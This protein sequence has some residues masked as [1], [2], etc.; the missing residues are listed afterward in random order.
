MLKMFFSLCIILF[1]AISFAAEKRIVKINGFTQIETYKFRNGLQ[2]VLWPDKSYK[3]MSFHVWY[4]VGSLHERVG[5]TGLAHLFEHLM[6]RPSKFAP[7]G[8][9]ALSN[10]Y[11]ADVVAHTRFKTTDYEM[12]A[13]SEFLEPIAQYEADIM[14]NLTVSASVLKLEKEAVRSEYLN[15]DNSPVLTILP[16]LAAKLYPN[17]IAGEFVTGRRSDL[18]NMSLKNCIDFYKSFYSPDNAIITLTGNF[19]KNNALKIIKRYFGSLK[20][21]K[22]ISIPKDLDKKPRTSISSFKVKGNSRPMFSSFSFPFNTVN[23][24]SALTLALNILFDGKTSVVG[25]D[26]F[27]K[28]LVS[29]LSFEERGLG[30]NLIYSELTGKNSEKIHKYIKAGLKKLNVMR[31]DEFRRFVSKYSSSQIKR[32]QTVEQR[33]FELGWYLTHR[34]GLE[35]L[36]QDLEASKYITL[37]AVQRASQKYLR[38]NN[39]ISVV[40]NPGK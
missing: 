21:G 19:E 31:P 23:E 5:I 1:S 8:G 40:G 27:K 18:N 2:L 33:S 12:I 11:A 39:L 4:K 13:L 20:R 29:S 37:D 30:F 14:N 38:V 32:L 36:K 28:G 34:N 7:K 26:L 10:K 15:W 9:L 6:L 25:R 35:S 17:H 16:K 3:L 24:D 22:P